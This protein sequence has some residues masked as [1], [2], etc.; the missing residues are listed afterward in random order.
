MREAGDGAVVDALSP[1]ER[2]RLAELVLPAIRGSLSSAERV[3]LHYDDADDVLATLAAE[4][5]PELVRRGMATPEHLLRAGRLPVW[6]DHDP[7]A[8]A[9]ALVAQVRSRLAAARAEY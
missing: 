8:S 2:H 5:V 1:A 3:I 7:A 4:R 9:D 6:L